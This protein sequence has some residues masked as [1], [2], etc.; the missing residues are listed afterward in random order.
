MFGINYPRLKE[1]KG[2]VILITAPVG[3]ATDVG[4]L[5]AVMGRTALSAPREGI[6]VR[7]LRVL[8]LFFLARANYLSIHGETPNGDSMPLLLY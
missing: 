2:G 3:C 5:S 1:L 8:F 7:T 4:Y 6:C